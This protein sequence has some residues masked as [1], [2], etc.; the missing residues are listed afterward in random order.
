[1]QKITENVY[2]IRGGKF[3]SHV[4]V[5]DDGD[6]YIL[7]DAGFSEKVSKIDPRKVKF[8]VLTHSHYDHSA[9]AWRFPNIF[10]SYKCFKY[11]L[12]WDEE[13]MRIP[14]N[15]QL[16]RF[17]PTGILKDGNVFNGR[18]F[19][20]LFLEAPSH[21]DDS[22]IIFEERKRLLFTG[23]VFFARGII[24]KLNLKNSVP[25]NIDKV[26]RRIISLPWKYLLPGHGPI[27]RRE[28]IRI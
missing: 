10:C 9:Q 14:D 25:E 7:I 17:R 1:M 23:D 15:V 26:I 4:Y 5:L 11:I 8:V 19:R 13:I 16:P 2:V 24:G 18:R 28:I 12:D 27:E 22:L 3:D 21:T 20:L 6:G